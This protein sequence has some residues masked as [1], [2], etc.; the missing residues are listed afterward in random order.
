MDPGGNSGRLPRRRRRRP[1]WYLALA[2]ALS[3][4]A[5]LWAPGAA[6]AASPAA[7]A[8][9]LIR[10]GVELRRQGHN[11]RALPL[12]QR[13]YQLARNPRTAGQL[14]LCELGIG[15]WLDADQHLSEALSSAEHPW[16]AKN[17]T[18]LAAS[19]ARARTNIGELTVTG[20]PE[21]AEVRVNGNAAG[22]LPLPRPLRLGRG[23]VD[24][25]VRAAGYV[26]T[27]RSLVIGE[28]P[29]TLAV[30][31]SR[32]RKAPVA[33][34]IARPPPAAL[35]QISTPPPVARP[36]EGSPGRE[37]RPALRWAAIGTASL[38]A[39]ALAFAGFETWRWQSGISDFN[40]HKTN[41]AQD[42]QLVAQLRGGA[43]CQSIYDRYTS[44]RRLA[45]IGYAGGGGLTLVA[46]GLAIFSSSRPAEGER[47]G[48]ACAPTLEE[49]GVSCRVSF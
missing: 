26:T 30:A 6:R 42:C 25:E 13:A 22:Q 16:V 32:E 1:G 20:T 33:Q 12:F 4:F 38:A 46:V 10:Q 19:L 17:R 43:A 11:E 15:Y 37:G 3:V 40:H 34:V 29:Q 35:P 48:L 39:A 49:A 27:Q 21:G 47:V 9:D 31:L 8:E 7:E 5:A 18:Q 2:L 41:T 24:V 36:D 45:V 14:G 28:Q 23:P 44:A